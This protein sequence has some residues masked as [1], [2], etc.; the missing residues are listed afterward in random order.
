MDED[1][2][3]PDA[4]HET[5]ESRAEALQLPLEAEQPI[6]YALTARARRVVAPDDVPDLQ[7]VDAQAEHPVV[8][9]DLDDPRSVQARALRRAGMPV[10][11]IAGRLE[12]DPFTVRAWLGGRLAPIAIVADDTDDDARHEAPEPAAI[13]A[14]ED[15]RT[16]P[17]FGGGL[18]V[19]GALADVDGAAVVLSS[20]RPAPLAQGLAFLRK[21]FGVEDEQV[22]VVLRL[23]SFLAGDRAI[24][25]WSA[26][27]GL[28]AD[29]FRHVRSGRLP[30]P[31][32]IEVLVRVTGSAMADT[33]STWLHRHQL[34]WRPSAREPQA[35][36][37]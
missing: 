35:P 4:G 32:G 24:A 18:A 17:D 12:V 13:E 25:D 33:V 20:D 16:D 26:A 9:D 6:P 23:G 29:R 37:S 27:L 3:R 14:F 5:P 15:R 30:V 28:A 34:A 22:R 1:T 8:E 10:S 31:D 7:V 21:E 11:A 2:N 36:A 19:L